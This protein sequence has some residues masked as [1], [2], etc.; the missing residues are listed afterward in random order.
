MDKPSHAALIVNLLGGLE[1]RTA[2]GRDITPSGKKLRA[3]IACLALAPA[4]GWPRERLT[5]IFWGDRAEEQARASLRQALAEIRRI[6]GEAALQADRDVVG[7]NEMVTKVDARSF[8]RRQ[9]P[10]S[11]NGRLISTAAIFST[12]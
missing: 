8:A 6:V 10:E 1:I 2:D 11:W 4:G 5:A 3:L 7:F 9:R 12:A